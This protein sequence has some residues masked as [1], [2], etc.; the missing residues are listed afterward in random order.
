MNN[1]MVVGLV[2]IATGILF[3]VVA[4]ITRGEAYE[5]LW[6]VFFVE[7]G[8]MF[9]IPYFFNPGSPRIAVAL[10]FALAMASTA[11]MW[12]KARVKFRSHAD[13]PRETVSRL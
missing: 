11:F 1:Q 3:I 6:G 5:Y 12:W 4:G 13:L 10:F 2:L 8:G 9:L 7:W